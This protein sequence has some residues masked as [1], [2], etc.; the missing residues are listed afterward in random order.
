MLR[1]L[2]KPKVSHKPGTSFSPDLGF[3][4]ARN[5]NKERMAIEKSSIYKRL[6]YKEGYTK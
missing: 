1:V 4:A 6:L 3:S 5:I 2:S